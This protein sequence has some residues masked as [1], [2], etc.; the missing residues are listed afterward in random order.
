[1]TS[2]ENDF[3][4]VAEVK[5]A[6]AVTKIPDMEDIKALFTLPINPAADRLAAEMMSELPEPKTR[7]VGAELAA[8]IPPDAPKNDPTLPPPEKR[9][10]RT[11]AEMEASRSPLTNNPFPVVDTSI[12][13]AQEPTPTKHQSTTLIMP[14]CNDCGRPLSPENSSKLASGAWKHI[15]CV[16]FTRKSPPASTDGIILEPGDPLLARIKQIEEENL[17]G[18]PSY[19]SN[20]PS[21]TTSTTAPTVAPMV[22]AQTCVHELGPQTLGLL[23]ELVTAL[24]K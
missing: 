22:V 1:M 18:I 15:G 13:S 17:T 5:A 4:A 23:R 2:E 11:K 16:S 3:F 14:D 10:R 6:P 21:A 19:V 8:V 7:K 24:S 12:V 9:K 20:P